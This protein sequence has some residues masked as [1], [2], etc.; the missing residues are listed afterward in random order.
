MTDELE[1]IVRLANSYIDEGR[2]VRLYSTID[3]RVCLQVFEGG[4]WTGGEW[5][6]VAQTS[7]DT[8]F[9]AIPSR[10][11]KC[12]RKFIVTDDWGIA[13]TPCNGECIAEV[14]QGQFVDYTKICELRG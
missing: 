8:I 7:P 14:R 2:S 1:N 3:R 9:T 6:K 5:K 12:N 10:K 13:L 11:Y 4:Q